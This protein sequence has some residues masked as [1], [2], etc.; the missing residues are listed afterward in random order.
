MTFTYPVSDKV[1]LAAKLKAEGGP[2][3]DLSQTSGE[4]PPQHG[5]HLKW[6]LANDAITIDVVSKPFFVS[7]G[8]IKSALDGF[9]GK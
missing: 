9:F 7:E 2:A 1:A 3:I 4:L 6:V 5:V 8:Q